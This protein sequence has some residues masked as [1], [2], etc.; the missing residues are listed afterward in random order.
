MAEKDKTESAVPDK[1]SAETAL[2]L[3]PRP[4][5]LDYF[6]VIHRVFKLDFE[7]P[8]LES[9]NLQIALLEL[10]KARYSGLN[11]VAKI[12]VPDLDGRIIDVRLQ[13]ENAIALHTGYNSQINEDIIMIGLMQLFSAGYPDL[14]GVARIWVPDFDKKMEMIGAK[15]INLVPTISPKIQNPKAPNE[16]KWA[17]M[18]KICY[19]MDRPVTAEELDNITDQA[20][21]FPIQPHGLDDICKYYPQIV[22]PPAATVFVNAPYDLLHG[23]LVVEG[24]TDGAKWHIVSDKEMQ[25]EEDGKIPSGVSLVAV[26]RK[27]FF[28]PLQESNLKNEKNL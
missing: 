22:K 19:K 25:F 7:M 8:K 12:F 6:M 9:A 28:E 1:P 21:C 2:M 20:C 4:T 5:E 27:E 16:K 15:N 18:L 17:S 10:S 3:R 24:D 14:A 13:T 23:N 11:E 26:C